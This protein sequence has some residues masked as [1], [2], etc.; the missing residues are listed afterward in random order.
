MNLFII[1]N[2]LN[3]KQ[4][5]IETAQESGKPEL[6][7]DLLRFFVQKGE[8]EFIAVT[9]YTAYDLIRP[10]LAMEFAWRFNLFE[11]VMPYFI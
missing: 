4:D 2:F 1:I 5:A 9:L 8:K 11:F 10:D 7:E 6:V 3:S